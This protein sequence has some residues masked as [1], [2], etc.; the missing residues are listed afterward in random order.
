[1]LETVEEYQNDMELQRVFGITEWVFIGIFTVE[2]LIRLIVSPMRYPDRSPAV[3]VV[4]HLFSF[5]SI[6]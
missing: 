4:L 3:A 6:V 1:M 2:Y 5:F